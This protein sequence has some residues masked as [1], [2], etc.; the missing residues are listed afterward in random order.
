MIINLQ[1]EAF[2]QGRA[3]VR[4]AAGRLRTDRDKA[5]TRVTSFAAGGWTGIA[6]HAFL[7]AWDDWRAAA[8]DVEQGLVAMAELLDA[9]QRDFHAQDSQSQAD[10]DAISARIIERLG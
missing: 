3:D 5:D 8:T 10:L 4:D 7:E 2:N 1:D 9:T 6:A